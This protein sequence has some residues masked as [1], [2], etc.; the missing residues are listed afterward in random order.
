VALVSAASGLNLIYIESVDFI[1]DAHSRGCLET[2]E[3]FI[4][5]LRWLRPTAAAFKLSNRV[6]EDHSSTT[7]ASTCFLSAWPRADEPLD[8]ASPPILVSPRPTPHRPSLRH[9]RSSRTCD[10]A[11]PPRQRVVRRG[12][13]RERGHVKVTARGIEEPPKQALRQVLAIPSAG[14]RMR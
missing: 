9:A 12:T 5:D 1:P 11:A 7:K 3:P 4:G 10:E 2:D 6:G 13:E 14:R 8:Q